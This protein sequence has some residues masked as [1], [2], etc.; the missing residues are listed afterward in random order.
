MAHTIARFYF[1]YASPKFHC[2]GRPTSIGSV[3]LGIARRVLFYTGDCFGSLGVREDFLATF[4]HTPAPPT[5]VMHPD[6]S[7]SVC[8]PAKALCNAQNVESR[9]GNQICITVGKAN[10][11]QEQSLDSALSNARLAIVD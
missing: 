10:Y 2:D 8:S 3:I 6:S 1:L 4:H 11:Y 9:R 5:G 7:I